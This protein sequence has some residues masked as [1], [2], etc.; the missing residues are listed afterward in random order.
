MYPVPTSPSGERHFLG[1]S[2]RAAGERQRTIH[3]SGSRRAQH[4][5]CMCG[6]DD[7][8]PDVHDRRWPA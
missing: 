3:I 8:M 1:A 4:R 5:A 7:H 2:G 6:R